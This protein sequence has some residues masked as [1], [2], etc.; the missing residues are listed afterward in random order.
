MTDDILLRFLNQFIYLYK[1]YE[2]HDDKTI[3]DVGSF[4]I[5]YMF[6]NRSS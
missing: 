5:D 2:Y 1:L 4:I 3:D 6:I